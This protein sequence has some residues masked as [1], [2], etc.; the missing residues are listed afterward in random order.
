MTICIVLVDKL[1]SNNSNLKLAGSDLH[2]PGEKEVMDRPMGILA[3]QSRFLWE[4]LIRK[5]AARNLDRVLQGIHQN[6]EWYLFID[7]DHLINSQKE[8]IITG[9]WRLYDLNSPQHYQ[10]F[11]PGSGILAF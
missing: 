9:I 5:L 2:S 6:K 3:R 4:D 8:K 1:T 10:T 7:Q 11:F